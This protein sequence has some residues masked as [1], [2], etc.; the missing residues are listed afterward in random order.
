LKG[1]NRFFKKGGT[2]FLRLKVFEACTE[3]NF[4]AE[5]NQKNN[6]S[7]RG[8]PDRTIFNVHFRAFRHEYLVA[9]LKSLVG[10]KIFGT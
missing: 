2:Q 7:K 6:K 8:K 5:E 3:T 9:P 4:E 10:I 1:V